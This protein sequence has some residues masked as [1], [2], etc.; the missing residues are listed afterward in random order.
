MKGL[1]IALLIVLI[2]LLL[3]AAL[4]LYLNLSGQM[5]LLRGILPD[6]LLP[7]PP[8]P[9]LETLAR[10]VPSA[11]A[12]AGDALS[13]LYA[14]YWSVSPAG[15]STFDG[16]QALQPVTLTLLDAD[17]LAG[18]GMREALLSRLGDRV[19]L[20]HMKDYV[21]KG[22]E[23][24]ALA[25]GEG[26]MDYTDLMAVARARDVSMTLEN[27]CPENA[28]QARKYLLRVGQPD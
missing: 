11:A 26:E 5:E 21:R 20:L 17:A 3:A 16:D 7:K 15:E 4:V 6:F 18:A 27:T 28:E 24:P 14:Q 12:P 2:L 13:R 1:K 23:L 9:A 25:C 8:L 10:P 22:S 19:A